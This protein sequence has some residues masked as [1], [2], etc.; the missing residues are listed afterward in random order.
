[1]LTQD[2]GTGFT[3]W[4]TGMHLAGKHT[5]AKSL[6]D[7]LKRMERPVELLDG[8]EWDVFL[9]KGPG[10]TKEERNAIARRA[11]FFARTVTRA[12]GF[13]IVPQISPYRELRDQLR[14]EIGRFLEVFVDCPLETLMKRDVKGEYQ[15]A[16]R[17]EIR[18]FIGITD[19]YEP[20]G[21]PEVR[22]DS[23][24]TSP[25]DAATAI[26]EAL[27]KEGVLAP[28]DIG[29]ARAPRKDKKK[30]GGK[31]P[32]PPSILFTAEMLRMP[33]STASKSEAPKVEAKAAPKPGVESKGP[34]K[35]PEKTAAP[36][37]GA[38]KGTKAPAPKVVPSKPAPAK[39]EAKPAPQKAVGKAPVKPTKPAP[40]AA[41]PAPK[42]A[43]KAKAPVKL[44]VKAV[45]K[46]VKAAPVKAPPVKALPAKGATGAR[47]APKKIA[48]KTVRAQ[49]RR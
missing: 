8:G 34:A 22:I 46:A 9:G 1:M 23:G 6:A 36:A 12:G 47:S 3:I 13:A 28:S 49:K 19:P 20:P 26:L 21:S 27:V 45:V 37:K 40:K 43:P 44:P 11:G 2:P 38:E 31:K 41:K 16:I 15:K 30:S 10:G 35:A 33:K 48:A 42:P 7:R 14:R 18:N 39:P 4:L 25:D 5:I 32:N 17:G 29:L 24:S